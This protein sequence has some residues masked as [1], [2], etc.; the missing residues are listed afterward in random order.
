MMFVLVS[1]VQLAS[2][3]DIAGPPADFSTEMQTVRDAEAGLQSDTDPALEAFECHLQYAYDAAETDLERAEALQM[4]MMLVMR[5]DDWAPLAGVVAEGL[6]LTE[7]DTPEAAELRQQFLT[8]QSFLRAGA[9]DQAGTR[10]AAQDALHATALAQSGSWEIDG[11]RFVH[12]ATGLVCAD[13]DGARL[14]HIDAPMA[15]WVQCHFRMAGTAYFRAEAIAEH[16]EIDDRT[17]WL[18]ANRLTGA[19]ASGPVELEHHGFQHHYAVYS[20]ANPEWPV[21]VMYGEI[22]DA[23]YL[24]Q[25]ESETGVSDEAR[26]R[27][28]AVFEALIDAMALHTEERTGG[29]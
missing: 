27:I 12:R 20:G 9:G 6:S 13:T 24:L 22:G 26:S 3:A 7:A 19:P 23:A 11:D 2:C 5:S 25:A 28:I 15:N 29:L 21:Y 10:T 16:G 8:G 17:A 14:V 18:V 1:A 4:R